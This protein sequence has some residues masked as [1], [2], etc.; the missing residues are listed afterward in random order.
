M[1]NKSVML[2]VISFISVLFLFMKS[3]L[4][5]GCSIRELGFVSVKEFFE[6]VW[7]L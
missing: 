4:G 7:K 5:L 3:V 1:L 2:G 6:C